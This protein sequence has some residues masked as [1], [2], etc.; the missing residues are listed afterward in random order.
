LLPTRNA[1]WNPRQHPGDL[2][3][4]PPVALFHPVSP[5]PRCLWIKY[6]QTETFLLDIAGLGVDIARGVSVFF[7]GYS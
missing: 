1:P 3:E 2:D 6:L 5:M 4:M 7:E